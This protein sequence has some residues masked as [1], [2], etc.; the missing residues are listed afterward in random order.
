[1]PFGFFK[2]DS[3]FDPYDNDEFYAEDFSVESQAIADSY[4]EREDEKDEWRHDRP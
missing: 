4:E 3:E 2:R 1:M